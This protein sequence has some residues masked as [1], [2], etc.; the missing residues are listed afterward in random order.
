MSVVFDESKCSVCELCVA[1]CPT[2]A[3]EVRP[4]DLA[5]FE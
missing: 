3:M 2:R 4:S 1:A 5:F